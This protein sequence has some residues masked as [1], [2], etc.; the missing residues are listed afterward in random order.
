MITWLMASID[1]NSHSGFAFV[2]YLVHSELLRTTGLFLL[3]LHIRNCVFLE[4]LPDKMK[5]DQVNPCPFIITEITPARQ[6]IMSFPRVVEL[7]SYRTD[8]LIHLILGR[9]KQLIQ[10]L[11]EISSKH[12]NYTFTTIPFTWLHFGMLGERTAW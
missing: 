10:L 1:K 3:K 7:T 6:N 11:C 2:M 5:N 8:V 12:S 9:V 4:T